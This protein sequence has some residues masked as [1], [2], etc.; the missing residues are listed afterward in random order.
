MLYRRVSREV[1]ERVK[2]CARRALDIIENRWKR[3]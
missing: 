1:F 3:V 2:R